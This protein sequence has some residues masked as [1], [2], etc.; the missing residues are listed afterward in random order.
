MVDNNKKV[1]LVDLQSEVLSR[2]A[3]NP[4]WPG[5]L[6]SAKNRLKAEYGNDYVNSLPKGG[7]D[8]SIDKIWVNYE[9][10]RDVNDNKIMDIIEKFMPPVCTPSSAV[11]IEIDN[12]QTY[13]FKN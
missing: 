10:Q 2:L 1:K 4:K 3:K 6:Q 5:V 7:V 13:I 9:I 8:I 12:D 11:E